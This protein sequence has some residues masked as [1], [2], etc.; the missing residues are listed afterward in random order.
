MS[1]IKK[2]NIAKKKAEDVISKCENC[3]QIN[4]ARDYIDLFRKNFKNELTYNELYLLFVEK[5]NELNCP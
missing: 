4:Y 2:E 5:Q 1:K 3:I